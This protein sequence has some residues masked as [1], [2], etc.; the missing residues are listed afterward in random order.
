M[1]CFLGFLFLL[2]FI[3]LESDI[4]AT[5]FKPFYPF[6]AY[7]FFFIYVYLTCLGIYPVFNHYTVI[8]RVLILVYFSMFFLFSIP[9]KVDQ[10]IYVSL[11]LK[12]ISYSFFIVCRKIILKSFILFNFI[13]YFWHF[14]YLA[15]FSKF[16]F[17]KDLI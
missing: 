1:L 13:S 17:K 3:V 11:V 10:L 16:F 15:F 14:F 7:V 2:P 6:L 12:S 4:R 5:A 9:S 8:C